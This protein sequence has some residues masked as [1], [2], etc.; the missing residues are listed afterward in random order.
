MEQLLR[1][2]LLSLAKNK[3]LNRWVTRYG[4]RLGAQKFVAGETIE[5]AIKA[6]RGLNE[7][8][9]SV[10]VDHLG[11]FVSKPEDAREGAKVNVE[12]VEAIQESKVDGFLSV[13]M[14]QMGLDID[15]NLCLENMSQILD[16]AQ[17]TGML[18]TI[19][20]E[21]SAHCQ[22]TLD[23]Y[24]ELKQTYDNVGIVIQSYLYRSLEDV[25]QLAQ[26]GASLRIVKGAYKE[27]KE[28]AYPDKADVDANF[29]KMMEVSL[30][31]NGFTSI[32][33][34][35][36]SIVNYAKKFIAEN[37][38]ST[39]KYEFQMLYGISTH[40]QAQL[41]REGHPVRVYVPYGTDWYGYHMR[42][43]AERPANLSFVLRG[44][45][46]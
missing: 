17:K 4:L 27:P 34:H 22:I 41:V 43:L 24:H 26:E 32:A 30:K 2:I 20:M 16:T 14:T 21:D 18:V 19:D 5:S 9:M 15:R 29:I 1:S 23:I 13:K 33:T 45:F 36:E 31:G 3:L 37:H 39:N 40:L 12:T 6:I 44:L 7:Q 25:I 42:R 11:E 35:D 46:K 38:I 8:N 28:V 10:V